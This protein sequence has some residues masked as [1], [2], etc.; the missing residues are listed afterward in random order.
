MRSPTVTFFEAL[1]DSVLAP[2]A[3]SVFALEKSV[4]PFK[5]VSGFGM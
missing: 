1:G 4:I 3:E 2:E 5:S